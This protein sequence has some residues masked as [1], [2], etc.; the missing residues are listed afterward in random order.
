MGVDKESN[1]KTYD[2]IKLSIC[3]QI[4]VQKWPKRSILEKFVCSVYLVPQLC[5]FGGI[6]FFMLVRKQGGF[7]V[8]FDNISLEYKKSTTVRRCPSAG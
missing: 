8:C 6:D 3:C 7:F 5:L 2:E 1:F 4:V